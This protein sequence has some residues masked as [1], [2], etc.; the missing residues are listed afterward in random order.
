MFVR[1][2]HP[3]WSSAVL[4]SAGASWRA[5]ISRKESSS[6]ANVQSASYS[7]LDALHAFWWE[8]D[9]PTFLISMSHKF[10]SNFDI[11]VPSHVP[12]ILPRFP[13][14]PHEKVTLGHIKYWCWHVV[15]G[16]PNTCKN[17]HEQQQN[18]ALNKN[19]LKLNTCCVPPGYEFDIKCP[20]EALGSWYR[21]TLTVPLSSKSV[22]HFKTK[23]KRK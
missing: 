14:V 20:I 6:S 18:R 3:S 11:N 22:Y 7:S 1:H 8:W 15:L 4:L 2:P 10:S 5:K 17:Y 21:P 16:R 19:K 12:T 13:Q 9:S 23:S